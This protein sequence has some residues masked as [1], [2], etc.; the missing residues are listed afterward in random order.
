MSNGRKPHYRSL[1]TLAVLA[2]KILRTPEQKELAMMIPIEDDP[3]MTIRIDHEPIRK[4]LLEIAR[5]K[6]ETVDAVA[7][8][9][10]RQYF[11][12]WNGGVIYG[13]KRF[14]SNLDQLVQVTDES[15]SR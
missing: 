6:N 2:P 9:M 8:E 11:F 13:L 12:A 10:L 7:V 3:P 1:E 5:S 14:E 15:L 4:M